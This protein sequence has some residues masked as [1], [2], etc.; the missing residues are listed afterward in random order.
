MFWALTSFI[1]LALWVFF[2][3]WISETNLNFTFFSKLEWTPVEIIILNELEAK[4]QLRSWCEKNIP[5]NFKKEE[6]LQ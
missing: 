4:E 5:R 3:L 1:I 6:I 2:S